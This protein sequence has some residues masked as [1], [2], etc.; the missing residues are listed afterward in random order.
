MKMKKFLFF[1]VLS[2]IANNV[3]ANEV[4]LECKGIENIR[5]HKGN[6]VNVNATYYINFNDSKREVPSLSVQLMDCYSEELSKYYTLDKCECQ[7]SERFITCKSNITIKDGKDYWRQSNFTL[8]RYSG[9]LNFYKRFWG[10]API[11]KEI[12]D[13]VI[14]SNMTCSK[15]SKKF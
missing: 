9:K 7:V 14:T 3:Y 8:D 4:R 12:E 13:Q 1:Y 5:F 10:N 15:L 2:V 11:T 6:D